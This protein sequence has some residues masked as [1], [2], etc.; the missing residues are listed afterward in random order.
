[1][2]WRLAVVLIPLVL[3]LAAMCCT[4]ANWSDEDKEES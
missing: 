2:T 3:V 4:G 1:M